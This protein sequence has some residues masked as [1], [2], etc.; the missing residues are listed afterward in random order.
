MTELL[1]VESTLTRKYQK[2]IPYPVRQTLGLKKGSKISYHIQ[3][4]G[5]VIISCQ[6]DNQDELDPILEKFLDFLE[7][8]MLKHPEQ[9]KPITSST[10][11]KIRSIVGDMS[12]DLDTPLE[13]EEE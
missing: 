7:G 2:T 3:A 8:D 5:N 4:D 13:D 12:I 6:D 1:Q 11:N 10:V 9:I